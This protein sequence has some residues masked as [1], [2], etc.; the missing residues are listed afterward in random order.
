ML[1]ADITVNSKKSLKQFSRWLEFEYR[2]LTSEQRQEPDFIVI[3]TVKG[4]T[5]SFYENIVLHPRVKSAFLKETHYFDRYFAEGRRWY[6]AQFPF[7]TNSSTSPDGQPIITGEGTP[8]Y[9][10]Y[11]FVAQRIAE[12]YPDVKLIVLL[13]NPVSRAYSQ[14]H[15]HAQRGQF[16]ESADVLLRRELDFLQRH[17]LDSANF[18]RFVYDMAG[19]LKDTDCPRDQYQVKSSAAQPDHPEPYD[20]SLHG[21]LLRGIYYEQLRFWFEHFPREQFLILKSEDYF[22]QPLHILKDVAPQF[23]EIPAWDPQYYHPS[24]N[25]NQKYPPLD[26]TLREELAEF[27]KPYNEKLYDLLGVHYG[28]Q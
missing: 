4:G 6:R 19:P 16:T 12:N 8:N 26:T 18:E 15:M 24:K 13:R 9:L 10:I 14:Y 2:L 23:L 25:Q 1:L 17:P 11:P 22:A 20:D 3:G 5:T 27:F 21:L 7:S 28:W